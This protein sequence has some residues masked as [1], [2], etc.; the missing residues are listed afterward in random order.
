MNATKLIMVILGTIA[1]V[2]GAASFIPKKKSN[3]PADEGCA[4]PNALTQNDCVVACVAIV[5]LN[6]DALLN[7][8]RISS[9]ERK[10]LKEKAIDNC[11][12]ACQEV[13][14]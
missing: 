4:S 8:E 10:M 13:S 5:N 3:I 2:V 9:E 1:I 14:K 7:A 6:N 11:S 12:A